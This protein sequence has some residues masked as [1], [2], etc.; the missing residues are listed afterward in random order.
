MRNE[1]AVVIRKGVTA[2]GVGLIEVALAREGGKGCSAALCSEPVAVEP[3]YARFDTTAIIGPRLVEAAVLAPVVPVWVTF[4]V[5][6]AEDDLLSI[7]WME[8]MLRALGV[9]G[10]PLAFE[11]YGTGGRVWV[12]FGV[13]EDEVA[14]FM[15]GLVGHFP[16]LELRRVT[17]PFPAAPLTAVN[18]LCPVGPYHRTLSL[19]GK[20]GASPLSLAVTVLAG[21]GASEHGV[22]QVLLAPAAPAHDWHYNV[23]NLVEAERRAVE[24]SQLGGL[25]PQFSYDPELPPLLDASAREKVQVDVSFFATITRYAVWGTSD[26]AT[27]RFLQGLRVATGMLRFGNRAW[28][29]IPHET[30][31]GAL[32]QD[33]VA[34]MVTERVTHRPGVMLTSR[35]VASLVHLPNARSLSMLACLAQRTGV[36]W[37]PLTVGSGGARLG[38]NTFAGESRPVEIPLDVRLRHTYVL[39]TTGSGKSRL[40]ERLAVDDAVAGLGFCL[41]DPHGDLCQEVLSRLPDERLQDLVYVTFS[42]PDLVPVWNPFRT[43]VA[44]GK[45]ADDIARAFLAQSTSW[46]ARMEHNIRM[47]SYVVAELG[48]TL[49]DLAE[50]AS[51]SDQGATLRRD[52]LERTKNPQVQRFLTSE[53]P[54]YSASELGSV[55]NK[56]S[57]LLLDDRL[58]AMFSHGENT[59][60]PRSWMDE[61]RIVLVNLSSGQI[62]A[63][64]ARFVG[65]LLVSLLYRAALSRSDTTTRRPF[66]VYLDEFQQLQAATLSEILSE[67]RKY[68]LGA[69][70]AHQERG[71]LG[72]DLSHALGN[73]AINVFLRPA[74]DDMAF[75]HRALGGR[76][77]PTDLRA[78]GVGDAYV[79]CE[80]RMATLHTE[81]CTHPVRRDPKATAREYALAHYQ[82]VKTAGTVVRRRPRSYDS[83]TRE[84]DHP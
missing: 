10:G 35:E 13:G 17:D 41:V 74:E 76:T 5:Y 47:L 81:L 79:T 27:A 83:F 45:L 49:Q 16:A 32:G 69:I 7:G 36:A 25:S 43:T 66:L 3:P 42:E 71:Q 73:C 20:E 57:R 70:L 44:P 40:L 8:T 63:D 82:P 46:G 48:G 23:T 22:L 11:V 56:L 60:D 18:E 28:R 72:T 21:L 37:R 55:T 54:K 30:L 2:A 24:L 64:H 52:A 51:R 39:G 38:V 14:G 1:A 19:L 62:G 12:R 58:G 84:P 68:G 4:D 80:A 6:P 61:G 65:S 26:A 53:L 29:V 77:E 78:L 15:A 59:L 50:L 75:V 9:L 34:R 31:I 67:G 33:A